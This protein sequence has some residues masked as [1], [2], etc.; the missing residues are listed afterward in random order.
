MLQHVL[1]DVVLDITTNCF[2]TGQRSTV[3]I[4]SRGGESETDEGW[5]GISKKAAGM[6]A[7]AISTGLPK[8]AAELTLARLSL[9]IHQGS[10]WLM[11]LSWCCSFKWQLQRTTLQS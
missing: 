10:K 11:D 6:Q 9:S 5:H 7:P 3:R 1:S 2:A 8:I 4:L